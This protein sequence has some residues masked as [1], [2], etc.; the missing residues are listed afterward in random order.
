MSIRRLHMHPLRVQ[1][2]R[3]LERGGDREV[4]VFRPCSFHGKAPIAVRLA[5][6]EHLAVAAPIAVDGDPA[7][8]EFP[9]E[10]IR[11]ADVVSR[12]RGRQVDGLADRRVAESLPDSLDQDMLLRS[13]IVGHGKDLL[14]VGGHVR[15]APARSVIGRDP[16]DE[17]VMP[18]AFSLGR[19]FEEVAQVG[20]LPAFQDVLEPDRR[21]LG[22]TAGT[23]VGD[24]ADRPSRGY[25]GHVA[26]AHLFPF[27][28]MLAALPRRIHAPCVGQ[29]R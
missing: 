22:L 4:R 7:A 18:P 26:V 25:G 20:E 23:G 24:H 9:C 13:E 2:I 8:I 29:L 11:V 28:F 10:H 15:E 14:P 6:I 19:G 27:L 3:Q 5:Q 1:D 16:V 17:I 21:E 12:C